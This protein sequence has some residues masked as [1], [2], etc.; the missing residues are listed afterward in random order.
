MT[1]WRNVNKFS[2]QVPAVSHD[3]HEVTHVRY[4]TA[5]ECDIEETG[6]M[7]KVRCTVDGEEFDAFPE[8]LTQ[9]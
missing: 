7:S 6:Q 5:D 3:G 4:L 8:E 9:D 2:S 1:T